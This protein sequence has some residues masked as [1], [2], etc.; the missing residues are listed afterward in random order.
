MA[1]ERLKE[2]IW[3]QIATEMSVGWREAELI[4]W[5][6]GKEKMRKRGTDDSFPTT[7]INIPL[8]QVDD[9]QGQT[10]GQQQ[11]EE[12]PFQQ[13]GA[14]WPNSDWSGDEETFLFAQRRNGMLCATGPE[15]PQ[16]R[17]NELCKH[18]E[19][20]KKIMWAKIGDVLKIPWQSV[21]FIHWRLGI[22]EIKKRAEFLT[23]TA[24]AA[25]ISQ[26]AF[27]LA[28]PDEDNGEV[29]Q[30][31]DGE[32]DQSSHHPQHTEYQ[33]EPAPMMRQGRP[34]SSVT[35]PSCDEFKAGVPSRKYT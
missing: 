2:D 15:W 29:H 25:L 21:E 31:T 8:P 22:Q 4:H 34:E 18:Y 11:D 16:E 35:L 3:S 19:R 32:R 20:L 14:T 10:P 12:W 7:R 23:G 26:A 30:N 27:G 1:Y 6:L 24:G 5:L 33:T 9:A 13:Q 17:K 28:P